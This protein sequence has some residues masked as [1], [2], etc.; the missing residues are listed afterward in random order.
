MY[1]SQ[2][3][4]KELDSVVEIVHGYFMELGILF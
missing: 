1:G 2:E 4:V 3:T